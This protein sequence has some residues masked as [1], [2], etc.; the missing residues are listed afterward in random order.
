MTEPTETQPDTDAEAQAATAAEAERLAAEGDAKAEAERLAAENTAKLAEAEPKRGR[1][2]KAKPAE[3][4]PVSLQDLI[5]EVEG[6]MHHAL[7]PALIDTFKRDHGLEI[8]ED[9][10]LMTATMAGVE[11]TT[12]GG[13]ALAAM[14]GW[15]EAARRKI[16]KAA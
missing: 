14:R 16:L 6:A 3:E 11:N 7:M 15:C 13:G 1:P 8:V 9:G 5:A 10:P 2:A 12:S 4:P